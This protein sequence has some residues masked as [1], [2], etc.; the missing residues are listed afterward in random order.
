MTQKL[1]KIQIFLCFTGSFESLVHGKSFRINIVEL[2][3]FSKTEQNKKVIQHPRPIKYRTLIKW[4]ADSS[5]KQYINL[6]REAKYDT[7]S[8]KCTS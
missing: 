1:Q 4:S 2:P 6:K 7:S 8:A 5:G 3:W